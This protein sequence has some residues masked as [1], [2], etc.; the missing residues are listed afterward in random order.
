M[1]AALLL[2]AGSGR[3]FGGGSK[4]VADLGGRAVIRWC[5]E[6]LRDAGVDE[7]LV[8]VPVE[9]TQLRLAL[10]GIDARYVVNADA[11]QGIGTS[12]ACGVAALGSAVDA[13]LVA[14]ADEPALPAAAVARV[15]DRYRSVRAG[16]QGVAIVAPRHSGIPG[17]PVLF[18]RSVF[19]ELE[20]LRGDRGARAVVERDPGRVA[21][22]DV[23]DA[24]PGDVDTPGDLAR[25]RREPQFMSPRLPESSTDT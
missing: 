10:E 12:I 14:L 25:L 19:P 24:A 5:A 4:L 17:H 20:S 3:R 7:L 2:A 9:H 8:V 15:L 22:V 13:V 11:E 6:S 1:I 18:D 21:V 23:P 16:A